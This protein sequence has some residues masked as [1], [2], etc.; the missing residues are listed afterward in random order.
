MRFVLER[1]GL[2]ATT[3][4]WDGI[5]G[6]ILDPVPLNLWFQIEHHSTN[7]LV[8]KYTEYVDE[9]SYIQRLMHV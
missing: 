5:D 7:A 1:R 2:T 4:D 3:A 8:Q 9:V 6:D